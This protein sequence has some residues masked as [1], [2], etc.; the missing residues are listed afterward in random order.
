MR[1][2]SLC[3]LCN[4]IYSFVWCKTSWS[5]SILHLHNIIYNIFLS[6]FCMFT[7]LLI[8]ISKSDIFTFFCKTVCI[9]WKTAYLYEGAIRKFKIWYFLTFNEVLQHTKYNINEEKMKHE[10]N[11]KSGEFLFILEA[12]FNLTILKRKR[13]ERENQ[14]NI[15]AI[16]WYEYQCLRTALLLKTQ[17]KCVREK[18][19]LVK[20][21]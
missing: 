5:L 2:K 9:Q 10:T 14:S 11:I 4:F 8:F 7:C 15:N 21:L 18:C 16:I 12:Y 19:Q 20:K 17:N 6:L 3:T 1:L 13:G